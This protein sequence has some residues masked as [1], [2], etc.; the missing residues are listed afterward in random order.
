[1]PREVISPATGR[2]QAGVRWRHYR[3]PGRV[4]FDPVRSMIPT[5]TETD[6]AI[7]TIVVFSEPGTFVLRAEANDGTSNLEVSP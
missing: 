3:G 7:Q 1:M 6:V 4:R 2:A 5:A